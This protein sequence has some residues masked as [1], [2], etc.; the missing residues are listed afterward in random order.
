MA[1]DCAIPV[2]EPG[3]GADSKCSSDS[4]DFVVIV[5]GRMVEGGRGPLAG[6]PPDTLHPERVLRGDYVMW[7]AVVRERRELPSLCLS[8]S[9]CLLLC[10]LPYVMSAS[11]C[12]R[13]SYVMWLA[14]VRDRP[15]IEHVLMCICVTLPHVCMSPSHVYACHLPQ[16]F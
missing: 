1:R 3:V 15:S 9:L 12:L 8:T 4:I 6:L 2:K 5:A 14:V 10:L 7:L 11:S 16:K 13:G